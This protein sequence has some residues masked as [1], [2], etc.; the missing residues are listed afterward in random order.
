M[1]GMRAL[2]LAALASLAACQHPPAIG[3][4][5]QSC[6]PNKTCDDGLL[7]LSDLCVR[8]PPADC[9]EVA[10][11]LTAFEVGNY[12]EPEQRAATLTHERARC[13]AAHVSRDAGACI[14]K[15]KT[16]WEAVDCAP[17]LF[18]TLAHVT[19]DEVLTKMKSMV[20]GG[21]SRA[22]LDKMLPILKASCEADGWPT[23]FKACIAAAGDG[24]VDDLK[25][26][27]SAMP[28]DLQQKVEARMRAGR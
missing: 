4:E 20:G 9:G 12:A 10:E 28:K 2:L 1:S 13:E 15:A 5:R 18:P 14:A 23:A 27:E 24:K 3:S 8:P 6:R 22:E 16:R 19:C 25:A 7:C 26:C 11:Q 17:A 21:M